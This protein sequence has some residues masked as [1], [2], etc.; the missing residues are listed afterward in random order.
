M[1][2][3]L[4]LGALVAAGCSDYGFEAIKDEP[5]TPTTPSTTPSTTPTVE[6]APDIV[7]VPEQLSLTD[8]CSTATEPVEVYNRGNADLIIDT[9][10]VTGDGW[11]ISPGSPTTVAPGDGFAV[12][13]TTSGGFGSLDITSNDPDTPMLAVPLQATV[14]SLAPTVSIDSPLADEVLGIKSSVTLTGLVSDDVTPP[15]DLAIAWTSDVD[16]AIGSGAPGADGVVL[17]PWKSRTEGDHALTLTA[18]DACG[19][20]G[21][22]TVTVCQQAGYDVESLDIKT[23]N[24][25][26]DAS[27]DMANGWVELTPAATW[28]A[29]TAFQTSTTVDSDDIEI[30][31]AFYVSGGTGADGI[32]VTAL[33]STRMSGFVG[34][35]GGG[36]GYQGL[37]GWSIEVDTYYNPENNDPTDLDH[38]SFH[39]DGEISYYHAW[40]TLP[41]M[42]DGAWHDMSIVVSGT[43]VTV[44]I[45]GVVYIDQ[46]VPAIVNFPAYI[47]FTAATGSLSNSHLIDTLIVTE[48]ICDE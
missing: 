35:E 1:P 24:F 13:L 19:N 28:M 6:A 47:G 39:I 46:D 43:R 34:V 17:Q 44:A 11:S 48:F 22:D 21:S 3:S 40:A 12:D 2:R 5:E 18:T 20:V 41:E 10:T 32:S 26:G 31:F 27:W 23:W 7:V 8:I 29:G 25:E 9:L 16:G 4:L 14:D 38:V 33:D 42:E 37:P 45:D 36:I 15:E 30:D